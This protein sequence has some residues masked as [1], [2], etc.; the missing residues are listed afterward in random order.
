M[1]AR[2]TPT[3]P[4]VKMKKKFGDFER[5]LGQF[6]PAFSSFSSSCTQDAHDELRARDD[7]NDDDGGIKSLIKDV[8]LIDVSDLHNADEQAD[9]DVL[10]LKETTTKITTTTIVS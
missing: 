10:T 9:D 4:M 7:D 5:V 8:N 3:L 1:K 6:V 2:A